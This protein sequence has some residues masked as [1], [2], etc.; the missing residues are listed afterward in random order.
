MIEGYV[1]RPGAGKSY[2]MVA[3]AVK[4]IGHRPIYANWLQPDS[5]LFGEIPQ[6]FTTF[7][8]LE[9]LLDV[10]NALVLIDEIGLWFNARRFRET[11][12][13]TLSFFRQSRKN[14]LD[15]WYTTQREGDIDVVIREMTATIWDCQRYFNMI[16]CRGK[17]PQDKKGSYFLKQTYPVRESIGR[18]YDTYAIVGGPDGS[19]YRRGA[20]AAKQARQRF[21]R[22]TQGWVVVAGGESGKHPYRAMSVADL[23]APSVQLAR[24]RGVRWQL[25]P[26]AMVEAA[27]AY[28]VRECSD[29][30]E[31]VVESCPVCGS[32]GRR[33]FAAGQV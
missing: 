33:L 28:V 4:L 7:T 3:R 19:G 1:G 10:D 21:E 32:S 22:Y 16:Y 9:A 18:M 6:W 20:Y 14:G 26:E 27:R 30:V 2:S 15:L 17:D 25:I 24:R 11:S 31:Q 5:V 8:D 13:D 12:M 29:I 23:K